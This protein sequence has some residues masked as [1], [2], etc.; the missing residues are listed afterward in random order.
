MEK[1]TPR[2]GGEH[3]AN[4][5]L[6]AIT[7][8]AERKSALATFML[9]RSRRS[10]VILVC[11]ERRQT[12]GLG[13]QHEHE[14]HCAQ[15]EYLCQKTIFNSIQEKPITM[16]LHASSPMHGIGFD[17]GLLTRRSRSE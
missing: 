15:M 10:K 11:I 12:S 7:Q 9:L 4:F 16:N 1:T 3:I 13:I 14:E 5:V 17:I 6:G 8:F 2:C